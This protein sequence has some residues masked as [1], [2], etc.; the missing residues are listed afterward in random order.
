MMTRDVVASL[1]LESEISPSANAAAAALASASASLSPAVL[2][3]PLV[4]AILVRAASVPFVS[5]SWRCWRHRSSFFGKPPPAA[6]PPVVN[7]LVPH[8]RPR[9]VH[10]LSRVLNHFTAP[11][12]RHSSIGHRVMPYSLSRILLTY[13][14]PTF[15]LVFPTGE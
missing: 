5:E 3:L 15:P 14:S 10:S 1:T 6:S 4:A 11:E 8:R 7:N 13:P 9:R 12:Y 2:S